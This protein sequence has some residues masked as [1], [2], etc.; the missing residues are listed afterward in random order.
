M[1]LLIKNDIEIVNPTPAVLRYC[2]ENLVI[3][4]PDYIIAN[5]L[6]RYVGK[7]EKR[8]NLYVRNGNR[9]VLPFGCLSDVWQYCKGASFKCLFPLF[10]GNSMV[11]SINL[12]DYQ[13]RALNSLLRGRNGILEAP[14]GSG[15][16]QI[17]I[18]FIKE[19]GGKA[20]WLTHTKKLLQQ[21]K[22]R[23][24]IY[25]EGD[26][27]TITEGK[28]NIGRDITFA[29][30]QTMRTLDPSIYK[31]EFDIVVV[32]ECHH[33][34][35]TPTKVMQFYQVLTNLNC[36]YKLGLSATLTRSDKMTRCVYSILGNKLHTITEQEVGNKIIKAKHI[37]V[38]LFEDYPIESYCK[39]DG[40]I[41]FGRLITV[42][43]EDEKRNGEICSQVM[44]YFKMGKQQ[45]I[46][47]S[48]L[49]QIDYLK[50]LLSQYGLKVNAITGKMSQ[51]NRDYT[52]DVII[53]TFALAKEGLDIPKLDVVHF[54]VPQKDR[55]IVKQSAGRVE[56]NYPGKPQ[57]LIIDYVDMP[58]DYCVRAYNIR[59]RI[60]KNT[61]KN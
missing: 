3:D 58:I 18:Q 4:N 7:M 17:G 15:K 36:R 60:L 12:Y 9:V 28:V 59:K 25:F 10:K 8:L 47:C 43:S 48:R 23:A 52:G 22:E 33:C 54:A 42:L 21:S 34:V 19:V 37:K 41:D 51:K 53:A 40:M 5:K 44:N 6:G 29:T 46:L 2:E 56:R 32:D 16:T 50:K 49:N 31:N 55:A 30:I 11:G 26:F 20:L 61:K 57:P 27:G 1:E 14:C 39:P 35:G 24:E 38:E 13:Q 45:L